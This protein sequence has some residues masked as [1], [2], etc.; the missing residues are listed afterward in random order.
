[1]PPDELPLDTRPRPVMVLPAVPR[2]AWYVRGVL[3]VMAVGFTAILGTALW[4]NPY[5]DDGLPRR[6]A[7]H[8]QLGLP[9]CSMVALTGRPCPSCGMTT[10][11]ALLAHGDVPNSLRANWV[12]TLLAAFWFALIPWGAVSAFR[13]KLALVRNGE[14]FAT[15]AVG[16][17]LVL[18]LGR[19]AAIW[20]F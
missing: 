16:I 17:F 1:M 10:S 11:F 8:T 15:F 14:L 18:L 5:D 3:V 6:M 12:G 19:W 7:T 4:L 9:E 20:I 13:G 2:M